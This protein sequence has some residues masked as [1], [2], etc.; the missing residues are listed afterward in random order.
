A[1][2]VPFNDEM[3][4]RLMQGL[5]VLNRSRLYYEAAIGHFSEADIRRV[6]KADEKH[7][8]WFTNLF[9]T[10]PKG[11]D[12]DLQDAIQEQ[13]ESK[14]E[15]LLLGEEIHKLH[16]YVSD[17]CHPIPGDDVVGIMMPNK[18]IEVHRTNCPRGIE[19]MSQYGN[20]IVK[21][22][23]KKDQAVTFLTGLS[24]RG[25]DRVGLIKD[26]V[27]ILSGEDKVNMR[28][29]SFTASEGMFTG[30][31]MLYIGDT[32]HLRQIIDKLGA[33]EGLEKIERIDHAEDE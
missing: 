16:Y 19:L 8:N 29:I 30:K 24:L 28:S 5:A 15:T 10:S 7:G 4:H 20:R 22:K 26:V 17:C 12:I 23:W 21:A 25:F 31:I 33:V 14:P 1:V 18:G 2:P 13:V 27:E 11:K 32:L 9:R 3:E 6:F